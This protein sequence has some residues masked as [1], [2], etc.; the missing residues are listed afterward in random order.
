[1]DSAV[2][3]IESW[4]QE[5]PIYPIPSHVWY[6]YL[7]LPYLNIKINH[8]CS[9]IYNRPMDCLG[10]IVSINIKGPKKSDFVGFH[11]VIPVDPSTQKA[12]F[13]DESP[14]FFSKRQLVAMW[15]ENLNS[16][17][18]QII[19]AIMKT[20]CIL[21]ARGSNWQVRF[22]GNSICLFHWF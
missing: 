17:R 15:L 22:D 5:P 14:C 4:W 9:W 11:L 1:M 6:I 2:V 16:T 7:H 8:S 20:A 13:S 21:T 19:L 3:S 10:M 12:F 18:R